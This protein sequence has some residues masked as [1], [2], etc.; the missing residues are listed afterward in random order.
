MF[1]ISN[2]ISP[3][4]SPQPFFTV[5]FSL[6]KNAESSVTDIIPLPLNNGNIIKDGILEARYVITTLITHNETA[7]PNPHITSFFEILYCKKN[8][9]ENIINSKKALIKE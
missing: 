7:E 2:P 5:I 1:I 4:I 9:L 3:S 6:N 8:C